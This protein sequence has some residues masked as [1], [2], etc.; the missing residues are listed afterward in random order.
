MKQLIEIKDGRRLFPPFPLVLVT[1]P[2][3]PPNILTAALAH[4]FSFNPFIIG[5]GVDP[6]RHSFELLKTAKDFVIN[7]PTK[8][9]I[10]QVLFCGTNSGREVDKFEA[11]R[12]TD[13]TAQEV[14]APLI[15]ECPVNFECQIIQ[16]I[17]IGDHVW[18]LGEVIVVHQDVNYSKEKALCYWAGEF[19]LPGTLFRRR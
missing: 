7:I 1:I 4:V 16:N 14:E 5:I 19:R 6:R 3:K 17:E 13:V 10:E 15:G 8:R 9:L 2:G 12:L 11:T 18:F